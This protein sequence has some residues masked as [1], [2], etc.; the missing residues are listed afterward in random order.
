M[1]DV[2]ITFA[3]PVLACHLRYFVGDMKFGPVF[4]GYSYSVYRPGRDPPWPVPAR[5]SIPGYTLPCSLECSSHLADLKSSPFLLFDFLGMFATPELQHTFNPP[6]GMQLLSG[7]ACLFQLSL[8]PSVTV[9]ARK[10][11]CHHR[12][13]P[14]VAPDR[15]WDATFDIN[16]YLARPFCRGNCTPYRAYPHPCQRLLSLSFLSG[17][18]R[19]PLLSPIP[20]S[21]TSTPTHILCLWRELDL[22]SFTG[23]HL[24]FW[25]TT[26]REQEAS[27]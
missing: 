19:D 13:C 2:M 18:L 16:P 11:P 17:K 12:L 1:L 4:T 10:V 27:R 23:L 20:A 3:M 8:A 24:P 7:A 15:G 25:F 9:D 22:D 21:L 14:V 26:C 5:S 6:L